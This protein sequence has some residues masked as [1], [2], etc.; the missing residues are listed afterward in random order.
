MLCLFNLAVLS[1]ML[2]CAND[3]EFL[4]KLHCVRKAFQNLL[5][6]PGN[7]DWMIEQGRS[8]IGDL[9]KTAKKVQPSAITAG[10]K[11][12]LTLNFNFHRTLPDFI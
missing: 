8:I 5:M 3:E 11:R 9:M 6:I 7:R 10:Q 12:A 4:C 2:N 1:G